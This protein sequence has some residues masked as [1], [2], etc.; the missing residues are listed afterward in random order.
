MNAADI[1]KYGHQ[2]VLKTLDGLAESDW[3]TPGVCGVWSVKDI[4]AH[5]TSYELMLADVL[6]YLLD[7]GP[8]PTLDGYVAA[9]E[10]FNDIEVDR[11]RDRPVAEVFAE[12]EAAQAQAAALLGRI[13]AGTRCQ[14][15]TLPWYG[16]EYD[17]E[18]FIVY[19]SYGH[20][21]EH[22]AQIAVFRDQLARAILGE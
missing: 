16:Q 8:T 14:N 18:D 1:L 11:R 22:S 12:Y 4:L 17:L 3:H 9:Y 15:G 13:P 10:T 5:L 7:E 20:K 21:R 2:T 19:T 6:K